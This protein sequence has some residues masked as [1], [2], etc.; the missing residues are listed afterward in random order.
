VA[1]K[2]KRPSRE[3][4]LRARL[5]RATCDGDGNVDEVVVGDFLH[6]ERMNVGEWWLGINGDNGSLNLFIHVDR[7]GKRRVF[8]SENSVK[9]GRK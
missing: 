8:I 9:D 2:P 4:K 7:D 1:S 6:L 3:S 5:Q